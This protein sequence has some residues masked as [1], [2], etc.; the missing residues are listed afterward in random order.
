M[1]NRMSETSVLGDS[2][3]GEFQL[4]GE[5]RKAHAFFGMF[6]ILRWHL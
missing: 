1:G 4:R 3:F 6:F 5:E 2:I